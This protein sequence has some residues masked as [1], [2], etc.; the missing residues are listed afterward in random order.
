MYSSEDHQSN[1]AGQ[2]RQRIINAAVQLFEKGG[3]GAV[4]M[5]KIAERIEY[6][7]AA[8]YLYF[9]GKDD[10]L[11][12]LVGKGFEALHARMLPATGEQETKQ[13]LMALCRAYLDFASAEREYYQLMFSAPET[14]FPDPAQAD[15]GKP[16]HQ[17]Y[18]L[19]REAVEECIRSGAISADDPRSATL[20]VWSALHGLASLPPGDR[21]RTAPSERQD[22]VMED[23][24]RFVLR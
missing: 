15:E 9:K 14:R 20:G 19:M 16:A 11:R 18:L 10:I 13:R 7:P 1:A 8:I 22:N 2:M 17:A 23:V 24:L 12:A 6:S 21:T 4:S 3:A 5:R